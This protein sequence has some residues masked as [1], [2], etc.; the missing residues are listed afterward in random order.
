MCRPLSVNKAKQ[1]AAPTVNGCKGQLLLLPH[2]CMQK[3]AADAALSSHFESR[4][5]QRLCDGSR[6]KCVWHLGTHPCC[7][8]SP[9]CVKKGLNGGVK[10]WCLQHGAV[11]SCGCEVKWAGQ[12]RIDVHGC[13]LGLNGWVERPVGGCGGQSKQQ[14]A[15]RPSTS[16][17]SSRNGTGTSALQVSNTR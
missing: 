12:S 15:R 2:V 1:L 16:S 5:S 11:P 3:T 9:S 14:H 17:R 7:C 10:H 4:V 8:I 6:S 13:W